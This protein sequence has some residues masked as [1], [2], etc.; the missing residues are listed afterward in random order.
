MRP[1]WHREC[2]CKQDLKCLYHRLRNQH[3]SSD[4]RLTIHT[5]MNGFYSNRPFAGTPVAD[6]SCKRIEKACVICRAQIYPPI[7]VLPSLSRL[8]KSAIGEG[9]T[10]KDH[11]D[12]SNQLVRFRADH[13][14]S[15]IL[16]LICAYLYCKYCSR[17]VY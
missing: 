2:W 9:M 7:N 12:V 1:C 13:V 16:M 15:G 6:A 17:F 4:F 5:H 3:G 8:M 11:S 14:T 10:R